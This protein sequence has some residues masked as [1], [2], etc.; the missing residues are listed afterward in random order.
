L[1]V[2]HLVEFAH[3]RLDRGSPAHLAAQR[4]EFIDLQQ[5]DVRAEGGALQGDVG[6]D[7]EHA[8]VVVAHEAQPV[9]GHPAATRAASI[10]ASISLQQAGSLSSTPVIWWKGMPA[11]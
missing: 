8:A 9:V 5:F 11:R 3:A 2:E 6:V 7:V 4:G 10:H 1:H